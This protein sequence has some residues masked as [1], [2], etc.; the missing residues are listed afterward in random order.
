MNV[1]SKKFAEELNEKEMRHAYLEE[2]TRAKLAQQIRALRLQRDWSQG[3]LGALMHK[4]QSNIARLEDRDI[5]R[6]TLTS[7][8][9]LAAAF[10]VGLVVE[11][12]PY[13]EFLTRTQNL[14]PEALRVD[15]FSKQALDPLCDDRPVL[16]HLSDVLSKL[17]DAIGRLQSKVSRSHQES[18]SSKAQES[19][20]HAAFSGSHFLSQGVA[21]VSSATITG[22]TGPA[23]TITTEPIAMTGISAI[24]PYGM[25]W[26][27]SGPSSLRR[28]TEFPV[29]LGGGLL[30][31]P[32]SGDQNVR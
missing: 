19:A 1:I 2:K 20:M 15:S 29:M 31:E 14:S 12:V 23:M 21:T 7:L 5:A 24:E 32:V 10:D 28:G 6:Y 26:I 9:E 16:V 18:G 13:Q 30:I 25:G 22:P 4:P 11:F 8:F 27:V 3:N 17:S